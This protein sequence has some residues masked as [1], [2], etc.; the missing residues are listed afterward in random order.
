MEQ[1]TLFAERP[2]VRSY[3][4]MEE[5]P[6]TVLCQNILDCGREL[7]PAT[8][9]FLRGVIDWEL[10]R[11]FVTSKQYWKVLEIAKEKKVARVRE[12]HE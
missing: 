3:P 6:T 7:L 11:G 9:I 8:V 4:K 10:R 12:V 1:D 2:K 5:V